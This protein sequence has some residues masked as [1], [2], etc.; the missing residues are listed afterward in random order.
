[1][2]R[3]KNQ[4][5]QATVSPTYERATVS[6]PYV[7]KEN[8]NTESVDFARAG[9]NAGLQIAGQNAA[10]DSSPGYRS[11]LSPVTLPASTG[12]Y[13]QWVAPASRQGTVTQGNAASTSIIGRDYAPPS[14]GNDSMALYRPG[15]G[16]QGRVF[17]SSR[18]L[19]H[20]TEPA[21]PYAPALTRFDR[22]MSY[23]R[24]V[25]EA[26]SLYAEYEQL[27]EA[28]E[29]RYGGKENPEIYWGYETRKAELEQTRTQLVQMLGYMNAHYSEMTAEPLFTL[30]GPVED[31][32][33]YQQQVSAMMS[34]MEDYIEASNGLPDPAE[35]QRQQTQIVRL[36]NALGLTNTTATEEEKGY[37]ERSLEQVILGNYSDEVTLAGTAGQVLLGLTGLDVVT[38]LRDLSY[39]LTHFREAGLVQTLLDAVGLIPGVGI[40]K[41]ADEVVTLLKNALPQLM[42]YADEMATVLR[43]AFQGGSPALGVLAGST[44]YADDLADAAQTARRADA[45]TE[46]VDE[47]S[48]TARTAQRLTET[49]GVMVDTAEVADNAGLVDEAVDSGQS[50]GYNGNNRF[51]NIDLKPADLMEELANSGVKYTEEDVL[52]VTRNSNGDL[53]WLENGSRTSGLTHILERHEIDFYNKGFSPEEVP[54][55]LQTLVN[56]KHVDVQLNDRGYHAVYEYGHDSFRVIYGTNGYVVSFYPLGNKR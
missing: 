47:L 14:P 42:P 52:M 13:V 26:K 36:Q 3:K 45:L 21:N 35:L 19:M 40:L 39:D 18:G 49:G 34:E 12:G 23:E 4:K 7:P 37:W 25:E 32:E 30:S 27:R 38:D 15:Q 24:A 53:L 9:R 48:D 43:Q 51:G 50:L 29:E 20:Q 1:M 5:G 41:N 22:G 2:A 55:L 10:V 11:P 44:G 56:G 28:F 8:T 31:P 16:V 33:P 46:G 54:G 17:E 6:P